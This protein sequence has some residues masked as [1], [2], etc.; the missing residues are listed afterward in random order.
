[1]VTVN[2]MTGYA[3]ADG[4][5]AVPGLPSPFVWVWE[6]RSVNSKGLDVRVRVPNGFDSLEQ[7]ARQAA[8]AKLT[9]GSVSVS[10]QVASDGATATLRVNEPMLDALI[11]LAARKAEA[12]PLHVRDM[13]VAPARLDGLL[14]LRGVLDS[15]DV[16]P[17]E[18]DALAARDGELL[19]G[20]AKGLEH[21]MAARSAEGMQLAPVVAGHLGQIDRLCAEAQDAAAVQPAALKAR[22]T[23]ALDELIGATPALSQERLAQEV[24]LLA[25]KADVREELDRLNAHVVQARELLAKGAPCGRKLE[26]LSQ[27]FNREVNT[28]CSKSTDL[29]LT[30]LG[31]DLK[32]TVDQF[33]EQIQNIE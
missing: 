22:V 13:L 17:V 31:L 2:S 19:A 14:A 23:Q 15:S 12:L 11:E 20:F 24:A 1:M 9:R 7:P 26:F 25:L 10:L 5:C 16:A 18:A 8:A 28:L 4:R 6:I 3:R 30:R 29:A 32:A 33:R 21:L 27:E